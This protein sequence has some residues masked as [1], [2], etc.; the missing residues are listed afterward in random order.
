M[1]DFLGGKV[2]E[3]KVR[4]FAF[5]CCRRI[6]A[7]IEDEWSKRAIEVAE[8]FADGRAT[9]KELRAAEEAW[10]GLMAPAQ[11]ASEGDAAW[12]AAAAT[13]AAAGEA[14]MAARAERQAQANLLH[15]IFGNPFRPVALDAAWRTPEVLALTQAIYE[16]RTFERMPELVDALEQT[17]CTDGDLLRHLRG[18]APHVRGCWPVDALLGKA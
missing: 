8:A 4:L 18:P 9:G 13:A 16:E 6:W 3:R 2:S 11:A 17:G 10:A 14:T 1:L 7:L 12:A 15:C 5:A